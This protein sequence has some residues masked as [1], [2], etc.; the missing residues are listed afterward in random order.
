MTAWL[1]DKFTPADFDTS[2]A[3]RAEQ[4]RLAAM[5][6]LFTLGTPTARPRRMASG[7]R[8]PDDVALFGDGDQD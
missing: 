7:K 2:R 4:E 5:E 3:P 6:P 1:G 8:M